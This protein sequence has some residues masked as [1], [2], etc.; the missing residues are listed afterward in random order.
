MLCLQAEWIETGDMLY[1]EQAPLPPFY[2]FTGQ[3]RRSEWYNT[4]S[5]GFLERSF[6]KQALP[7]G[8]S[9]TGQRR[10]WI[11]P[12]PTRFGSDASA[13]IS[14]GVDNVANLR[15]LENFPSGFP[16]NDLDPDY[17]I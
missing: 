5:P 2:A 8:M 11:G 1:R 7:G 3:V 17:R 16:L 6:C 15:F 4:V 12:L 10:R 9:Q 13:L 14:S